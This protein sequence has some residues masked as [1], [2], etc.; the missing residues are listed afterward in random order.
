MQII[1]KPL[2]LALSLTLVQTA[3]ASERTQP[4]R[5]TIIYQAS[6]K[7]TYKSV[8]Q[9]N[10][11]QSMFLLTPLRERSRIT[12]PFGLRTHPVSGKCKGHKGV[13]YPAQKGTPIHATADGKVSFIG[14]QRGYGKV[15][16]L[17]HSNGYSTVYAHQ[18]RFQQGLKEGSSIKKG[19][20]IGYVGA[21]GVATGNHLHYELRVDNQPVDPIQTKQQMMTS[22]FA[23]R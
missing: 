18:S 10:S 22:T 12:S 13:D 17:D 9:Y 2:F 16:Y 19:Q 3:I 21:T 4:K 1:F 20:V 23:N 11:Q 15:I 14:A 7:H 6:D 8:A 5:V